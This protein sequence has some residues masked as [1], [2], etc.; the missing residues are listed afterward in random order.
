MIRLFRFPEGKSASPSARIPWRT[1]SESLQPCRRCSRRN[2]CRV[3]LSS[4]ACTISL[5]YTTIVKYTK[6]SN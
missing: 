6:K 3:W 4:L 1:T 5:M 2:I